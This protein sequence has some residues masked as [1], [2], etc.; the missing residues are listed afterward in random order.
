MLDYQSGYLAQPGLKYLMNDL[1]LVLFCLDLITTL[2]DVF[3]LNLAVE[4]V[5]RNQ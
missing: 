4:T 2:M 5:R 1:T 3:L